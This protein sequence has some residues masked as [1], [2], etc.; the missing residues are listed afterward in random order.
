MRT[1]LIPFFWAEAAE[2]ILCLETEYFQG[3]FQFP[4]IWWEKDHRSLPSSSP[5]AV[6]LQASQSRGLPASWP[7]ESENSRLP[8][9]KE[10]THPLWNICKVLVLPGHNGRGLHTMPRSSAQHTHIRCRPKEHIITLYHCVAGG[11]SRGERGHVY[12]LSLSLT[13]LILA[14]FTGRLWSRLGL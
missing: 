12:P 1:Q 13:V 6:V 5:T 10:N 9:Q 3:V 2:I 14:L 7:W 11:C 4:K 8:G